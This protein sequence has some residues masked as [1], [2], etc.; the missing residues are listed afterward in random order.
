MVRVSLQIQVRL[1]VPFWKDK[2]C[3]SFESKSLTVSLAVL[4]KGG[5]A[6]RRKGAVNRPR[7]RRGVD[8][9]AAFVKIAHSDDSG[10]ELLDLFRKGHE[11]DVWFLSKD[12]L[13][14][15]EYDNEDG[16]GI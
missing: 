8:E 16:C 14:G 13:V 5:E 6:S 4:Y 10:I 9:H 2:C 1:G 7:I 3:Q 15:L 11:A 12:N